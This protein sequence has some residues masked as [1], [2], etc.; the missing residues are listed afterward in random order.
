MSPSISIIYQWWI[1]IPGL[2]LFYT[3]KYPTVMSEEIILYSL[4]AVKIYL[5]VLGLVLGHSDHFQYGFLADFT[6]GNSNQ[7]QR[8]AHNLKPQIQK[9]HCVCGNIDPAISFIYSC[10]VQ[11]LLFTALQLLWVYSLCRDGHKNLSK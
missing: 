9:N 5:W 3:K 8:Y 6:V 7:S 11:R 10:Y 2:N 4:K 1:L